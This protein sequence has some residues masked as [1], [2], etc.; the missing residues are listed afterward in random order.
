MK[1][2]RTMQEMF[3][4]WQRALTYSAFQ[5]SIYLRKSFCRLEVA[6]IVHFGERPRTM[7]TLLIQNEN[8]RSC[9]LAPDSANTS[10]NSVHCL[11]HMS[12]YM[13][14]SGSKTPRGSLQECFQTRPCQWND[15]YSTP[16]ILLLTAVSST[17]HWNIC[18]SYSLVGSLNDKTNPVRLK[19]TVAW[20]FGETEII[21]ASR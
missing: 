1:I 5:S 14:M 9:P 6:P 8:G 4:W 20:N 11:K 13:L 7:C 3:M 21:R 15:R 19:K 17:F 12:L 10:D 16:F 2:Y 18:S